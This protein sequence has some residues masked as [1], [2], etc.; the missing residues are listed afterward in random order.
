GLAKV[1]S[2]P[3]KTRL[4]NFFLINKDWH[5]VDLPGYG[6]ARVSKKEK[7]NLTTMI[8]DYLLK[9]QQLAVAFVLID[10]NLP[11]KEIDIDF[12]NA[13][14]ERQIPF[15]IIFTKS[16]RISK[17]LLDKHTGMFMDELSRDWETLPTW[18]VSSSQYRLGRDEILGFI[19]EVSDRYRQA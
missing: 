16:D 4:L 13:L 5:L 12:I 18:F 1:S 3:G 14:G 11:P 9:R 8:N 2:T 19:E 17:A 6:F 7:D 10:S 15:A